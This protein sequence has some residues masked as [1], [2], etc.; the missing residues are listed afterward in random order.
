MLQADVSKDKA[1]GH[2]RLAI[3]A[4]KDTGKK[5]KTRTSA[6]TI[7]VH[8]E[9]VRLGLLAFVEAARKGGNEGWL[10]PPVSPARPA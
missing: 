10:F 3:Y 5:L 4:D 8:P 1:T 7:P 9:L 6:R 2:W